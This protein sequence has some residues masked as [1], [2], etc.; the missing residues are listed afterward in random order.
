MT[1]ILLNNGLVV[2]RFNCPLYAIISPMGIDYQRGIVIS[3]QPVGIPITSVEVEISTYC[4][5]PYFLGGGL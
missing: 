5:C 2:F 1:I 3:G 4:E